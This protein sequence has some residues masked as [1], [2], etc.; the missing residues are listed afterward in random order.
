MTSWLGR[1]LE[2]VPGKPLGWAWHQEREE[3]RAHLRRRMWRFLPRNGL[4]ASTLLEFRVTAIQQRL[5]KYMP[6]YRQRHAEWVARQG[7]RT[8]MPPVFTREELQHLRDHFAMAN[9][10]VGQAI[11]AKVASW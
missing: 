4:A 11:Y 2:P 6:T 1:G 8:V 9:D 3:I 10:P 5:H 7:Q